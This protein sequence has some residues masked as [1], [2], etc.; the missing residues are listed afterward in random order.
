M[1]YNLITIL[2][3]TAV[4]KTK[5]AA[6][7]ANEFNGEIISADSRQVYK[8]MDIGTGKDL[9]D[10]KIKGKTVLYHLIDVISPREEFDLYK[11]VNLFHQSYKDIN[12]RNRIPFL[13]GGTGLYLHSILSNYQLI[14]VDFNSERAKELLALDESELREILL[15]KKSTFH[16]TT[17]LLDKERIVKAILISESTKENEIKNKISSLTIGIYLERSVIKNRITERLKSRLKNG[18]IEE[19]KELLHNGISH[20]K[21][22]F[23]GLEY[24]Y[25]SLFIKGELSYNDMF[26]KL[27]SAIHNFA[28][29]QMTW[30][31]KM[32]REGIKIHWIEGADYDKANRIITNEF[33]GENI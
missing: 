3:P 20:D 22:Q 29:R 19:V 31:R 15:Q 8:G 32:E 14:D 2:G 18:M 28:K 33:F 21:L 25:I 26:Q 30:F 6:Q 9:D 17:D 13:V 23:F 7:L 16:N 10:Y 4:G 24:K 5:L 12:S 1:S 11:F 27:N